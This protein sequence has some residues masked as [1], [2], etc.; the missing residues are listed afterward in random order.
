MSRSEYYP[1]LSHALVEN[2][3]QHCKFIF[4]ECLLCATIALQSPNH[5]ATKESE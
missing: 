5:R 3:Y 2:D 1:G 4:N